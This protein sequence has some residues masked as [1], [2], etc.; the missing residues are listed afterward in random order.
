MKIVFYKTLLKRAKNITPSE[1]ILYSFLVSKCISR[2]D[3]VFSTDGTEINLECLYEVLDDNDN[4]ID[5]CDLNHTKIA[6]EI[7]QDRK[8]VIDGLRHLE[9]LGYIGDSW[10]YVNKELVEH[11]YFELHHAELLKGELLIFYSYL[12]DKSKIYGYCI[13]TYKSKLAELFGKS[14]V[15]ITKLLYRL[16]D[17]GLAQRLENGELKLLY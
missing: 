8:T 1:R 14:K 12:L 7:K 3:C 16:Y 4:T 15:A 9:E 17:I 5:L 11:G 2:I 6:N 10:I 13:D